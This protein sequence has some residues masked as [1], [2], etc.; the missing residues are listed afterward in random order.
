[1]LSQKKEPISKGSIFHASIY[2]SYLN[3]KI[4][5]RIDLYFPGT[6]YRL[7]ERGVFG[8]QRANGI[9]LDMELL[10]LNCS[11]VM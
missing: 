1:M 11:S 5:W 6:W 4:T 7:Q 9:L 2:I 10:H 3:D 8:Y